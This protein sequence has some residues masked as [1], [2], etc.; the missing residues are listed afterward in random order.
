MSKAKKSPKIQYGIEIT[1]PWSREMYDHNDI[2]SEEMKKNIFAD[3]IQDL[4]YVELFK[5]SLIAKKYIKKVVNKIKQL[6]K[7]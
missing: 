3:F 4:M 5:L 7:S 1:K 2:V 6:I